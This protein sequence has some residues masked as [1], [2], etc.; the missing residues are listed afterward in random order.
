MG[1]FSQKSTSKQFITQQ[2]RRVV[3]SG[4]GTVVQEGANLTQNIQSSDA[5][6]IRAGFTDLFDFAKTQSEQTGKLLGQALGLA[7]S[8]SSSVLAAQGEA[9]K[10]VDVAGDRVLQAQSGTAGTQQVLI[11]IVAVAGIAAAAF[12][13]PRLL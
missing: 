5:E 2:D 3:A 11:A 10:A 1:L 6:V 13:V 9:I 4:Q 8:S 7:E 12:I